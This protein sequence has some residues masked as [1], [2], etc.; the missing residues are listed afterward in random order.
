MHRQF[1]NYDFSFIDSL[2]EMIAMEAEGDDEP[3][4]I[5]S[6]DAEERSFG[7]D[8]E[9]AP[10]ETDPPEGDEEA[11]PDI[12]SAAEDQTEEAE[13][14]VDEDPGDPDDE[15][16][17]DGIDEDAPDST[18]D[19]VD[20]IYTNPEK[21]A[22][23]K[24]MMVHLYNTIRT[25][26][27]SIASITVLYPIKNGKIEEVKN[28]LLKLNSIIFKI[29]TNKNESK[30]YPELLKKYYSC[31]ELYGVYLETLIEVIKKEVSDYNQ[32]NLEKAKKKK[33]AGKN[34]PRK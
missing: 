32:Q 14:D 26:T 1:P 11:T 30:N 15:S 22:E 8:N 12:A 4:D 27:E 33:S 21:I 25:T 19:T 34:K 18:E 23:V 13:G 17:D 31:K 7:E 24:Q 3:I 6:E 29:N 20:D 16:M 9:D 2:N 28:Q 5:T 10:E